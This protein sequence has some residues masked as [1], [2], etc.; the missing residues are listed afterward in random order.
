MYSTFA[1]WFSLTCVL[2]LLHRLYCAV[3]A[4]CRVQGVRGV[5]GFKGLPITGVQTGV[6]LAVEAAVV[7]VG[8]EFVGLGW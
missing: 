2:L 6:R 7:A 8:V 5:S 4:S 3:N 1:F